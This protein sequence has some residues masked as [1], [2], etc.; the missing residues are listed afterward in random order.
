VKGHYI[1]L[2]KKA[3]KPGAAAEEGDEE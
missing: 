1:E 2:E 3:R